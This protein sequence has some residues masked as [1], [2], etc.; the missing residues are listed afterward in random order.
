MV[1]MEQLSQLQCARLTRATFRIMGL[2]Q[3]VGVNYFQLKFFN[4]NDERFEQW[5]LNDE[6][7]FLRA[8]GVTRTL[9]GFKVLWNIW[10]N[11]VSRDYQTLVIVEDESIL[12]TQGAA[13]TAAARKAFAQ[14]YGD[15]PWEDEVAAEPAR[16]HWPMA[17]FRLAEHM[18]AAAEWMEGK[19]LAGEEMMLSDNQGRIAINELA[20]IDIRVLT[21]RTTKEEAIEKCAETMGKLDDALTLINTFYR[22]M[23]T[24]EMERDIYRIF[25]GGMGV[26]ERAD[27]E[28]DATMLLIRA[29]DIEA[30][31]RG[32]GARI[33]SNRIDWINDGNVT[34]IDTLRTLNA[35]VAP[36]DPRPVPDV[37]P[38]PVAPAPEI[39]YFPDP[40]IHV[41][42][43][44]EIREDRRDRDRRGDTMTMERKVE[45]YKRKAKSLV[46]RD[47]TEIM[48]QTMPLEKV[49]LLSNKAKSLVETFDYL[50]TVIDRTAGIENLEFVVTDNPTLEDPRTPGTFNTITQVENVQMRLSKRE[51][52]LKTAKILDN[53]NVERQNK[54]SYDSVD[55]RNLVQFTKAENFLAWIQS[56]SQM[57]NSLEGGLD[58]VPENKVVQMLKGSIK[59]AEDKS[60][61][62]LMNTQDHIISYMNSKYLGG[63]DIV[64]VTFGDVDKLPNPNRF[65]VAVANCEKVIECVTMIRNVGL[66]N[67]I[68]VTH[69][70][71]M[72]TKCMLHKRRTAYYEAKNRYLVEKNEDGISSPLGLTRRGSDAGGRSS[73]PAPET[74]AGDVTRGRI[75]DMTSN[76]AKMQENTTNA[77]N[78]N[79]FMNYIHMEMRTMRLQ[80]DAE[81]ETEYRGNPRQGGGDV[82]RIHAMGQDGGNRSSGG[83]YGGGGGDKWKTDR[84]LFPC[85]L[86]DGHKVPFGSA[87]YCENFRKEKDLS[88]RIDKVKKY[89]MCRQCLKSLQKVPHKLEDCRAKVCNNCGGTHNRLLCDKPVGE[90]KIMAVE[91]EEEDDGHDRY[92]GKDVMGDDVTYVFK[93]SFLTGDSEMAYEE[94]EDGECDEEISVMHLHCNLNSEE[95]EDDWEIQLDESWTSIMAIMPLDRLQPVNDPQENEEK[96]ISLDANPVNVADSASSAGELSQPEGQELQA[97]ATRINVKVGESLG[98]KRNL[99]WME[100]MWAMVPDNVWEW[101]K[102]VITSP[103][104]WGEDN[105]RK[106]RQIVDDATKRP[107]RLDEAGIMDEEFSLTSEH[108]EAAQAISTECAKVDPTRDGSKPAE[109]PPEVDCHKLCV[110][111]FMDQ[112]ILPQ[113]YED[114]R[115]DSDYI[116]IG[117]QTIKDE[118][119]KQLYK[120]MVSAAVKLNKNHKNVRGMTS[121]AKVLGNLKTERIGLKRLKDEGP[122]AFVA[123]ILFDGGSD[124]GIYKNELTNLVDLIPLKTQHM[125]I[126]TAT[127]TVWDNFP[128]AK[129]RFIGT[130]MGE[131]E[132]FNISAIGMDRIGREKKD[133]VDYV[134]KVSRLFNLSIELHDHLIKQ[135][136]ASEEEIHMIVG[137]KSAQ[138]LLEEIRPAQLK[139]RQPWIIPNVKIYRNPLTDSLIVAGGLGIEEELVDDVYPTFYPHKEEWDH[140]KRLFNSK[141]GEKELGHLLHEG[142]HTENNIMMLGEAFSLRDQMEC[143]ETDLKE[144]DEFLDI[145]SSEECRKE[146][147]QELL[148]TDVP[149]MMQASG[150]IGG[151]SGME[152]RDEM[153]YLDSETKRNIWEEDANDIV[154]EE[155][156][157]QTMM[158]SVN[159]E[160]LKKFLEAEA[161]T[162]P[163]ERCD[164]CIKRDCEECEML[165]SKYSAEDSK[166]YK[167]MWSKVNLVEHEGKTRVKATYIYRTDPTTTFHKDHSNIGEAKARTNALI[168][169]LQKKNQLAGF[170]A[171]VDK[172]IAIG[173]LK[174]ISGEELAKVL[175]STHHFCYLSQVHSETS[176][177]TSTRMINDTLTN[178]TAGTGFSIE[179]KMPVCAIGN[180][181]ESIIDWR[182]HEHGYSSDIS[183]CY[184]RVLV[185]EVTSKLRLC[186]WYHDPLTKLKPRIFMRLTMDFGDACS[187]L[188]IR[189]IQ[190]KFLMK[191]TEIE[192]VKQILKTGAYADNYSSSFQ[193][194][195][196][197]KIAKEEMNRIHDKIGLPLKGTYCAVKTD[198]GVL[199]E[200]EKDKEDEPVYA[201]LGMAWNLQRDDMM[202][203]ARFNLGK[204][205]KGTSADEDL[206]DMEPTDIE[207]KAFAWQLTR[208]RQRG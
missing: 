34:A 35:I 75:A 175:N 24:A 31:R 158:T 36:A 39:R 1:E 26:V 176:E 139:V 154:A 179:N 204:K 206:M 155:E 3:V 112:P 92:D 148:D 93:G 118:T 91:V 140:M 6:L 43:E 90:Q 37:A 207:T 70:K 167:E 17:L 98:Q 146:A 197:Y 32:H 187:S 201:F 57:N 163:V 9:R 130:R 52:E 137:Q 190:L 199:V 192:M 82:Q 161:S 166:M 60:K 55:S 86:K 83:A 170:Q 131:R 47:A 46:L 25:P 195:E 128:R 94:P 8:R 54:A 59:Y 144:I 205:S 71:N 117:P 29:G 121:S 106:W 194:K 136:D 149:R 89:Q 10:K 159:C 20:G 100:T 11:A 198:A 14:Q 173:C 129:I 49:R 65:V 87:S 127:G 38:R 157:E 119:E 189:I 107:L 160:I 178:S 28:Y 152:E 13:Y 177:S 104:T 165:K 69:L 172:K 85:P 114:V 56:I 2:K 21:R 45:M 101:A 191:M 113:R 164:K 105:S 184:L 123:N 156:T 84:P 95:N 126:T 50:Y 58:S 53:K 4:W 67:R 208:K 111:K 103:R 110:E 12:P 102:N 48:V 62:D 72:E 120:R 193:T 77:E 88:L 142:K 16:M 40:R 133:M 185:D 145:F 30:V 64:K 132:I 22:D 79:F 141:E 196:E 7:E 203:L 147:T 18:F 135:A 5:I 97:D 61:V 73:T 23:P 51:E 96:K 108:S 151:L 180:S 76:I 15:V 182:L 186:Y 115:H 44:P 169:K 168:S 41:E 150:I 143:N 181:F 122:A 153:F 99:T 78:V 81:G 134:T 63:T 27:L 124:G 66:S 183:K 33:T 109:P 202:P 200:L 171:E 74:P 19:R 138:L 174:E 116:S 125:G 162:M 80:M 188:V 68:D 42:P